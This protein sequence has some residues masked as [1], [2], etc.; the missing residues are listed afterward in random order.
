M[1]IE[2]VK[3]GFTVFNAGSSF[4]V[5]EFKAFAHFNPDFSLNANRL[6]MSVP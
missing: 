3:Q 1:L 4:T 5:H 2:G 6:R